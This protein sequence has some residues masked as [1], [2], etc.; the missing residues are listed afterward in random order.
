[1]RT[2]IIVDSAILDDYKVKLKK[3]KRNTIT[4]ISGENWKKKC[5]MKVTFI[6]IIIRALGTVT[7]ELMKGI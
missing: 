5:N 3:V 7:E 2:C 4:L 1:M 6:P